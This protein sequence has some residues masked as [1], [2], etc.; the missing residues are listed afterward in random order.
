[1]T[2]ESDNQTAQKPV[3]LL[4]V[5]ED[6]LAA[7]RLFEMLRRP[8][9]TQFEISRVLRVEEALVKLQHDNYDV[10]LIDLSIHEGHGLDSLLRARAATLSVPIVVLTYQ[11]DEEV[12]MKAAR[13]G[14]QDYLTKGEVTRDLL[15]RT[16]LHAIERHRM[17]REINDSKKRQRFLATH[18]SLT[19]LPNR[20]SFMAQLRSALAHAERSGTQLAVM[21]LDL[22]GFKT[23]NDNLGHSV[24]D[25]L[26][27]DVARRLLSVVRKGD[28]VARVGGDEF[29]ICVRNIFD[30]DESALMAEKIREEVEQTYHLAGCECWV[31]A[32]IGIAT[33]PRDGDDPDLLIRQADTAMYEVKSSG[34]NGVR[35]FDHQMDDKVAERFNLVNGLRHAIHDGQLVLAFQ[36]QIQVA[37]EEIVGLETLVRWMHPTRG[38]ISPG[39]FIQVAEE[40]GLM[41]PLGEWVLHEAC[42]CAARWTDLAGARVAVNISGRQLEQENFPDRV[43]AILEQTGLPAARLEIE[44]TE[45][46]AASETALLALRRLREMGVRAAIDDFGTGYSSLTLLRRLN[47]DLLKIDQSFVCGAAHTDPDAVILEA[48]IH[49]GKGLGM[50]VMAEGVETLEEM[51]LL[52]KRGCTLMQGYLF[53]KPIL[54]DEL[55]ETVAQPDALWR[56]PISRPE[57]WSPPPTDAPPAVASKVTA[58]DDDR[59]LP[60]LGDMQERSPDRED[61]GSEKS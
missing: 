21:F 31:S 24:G 28:T 40:T 59:D 3:T 25:E 49:I 35:V 17:V 23:V 47:V 50:E 16:L 8:E 20:S 32:S 9:G 26:L 5:E 18:D 44:L 34:K 43:R 7:K 6:D 2:G 58:Y 14:A 54:R 60:V 42:R 10:M 45:S 55:E 37:T 52:L 38:M 11:R 33:Y 22:D 12:A 1:M 36:P 19:E 39:E 57:S 61:P 30:P 48:I 29:L 4:L 27:S 53:A 41:I 56:L 46:V 13:A 51:D 15:S